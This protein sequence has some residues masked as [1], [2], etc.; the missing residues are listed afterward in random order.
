MH[1]RFGG[2]VCGVAFVIPRKMAACLTAPIAATS[3]IY[4]VKSEHL[5]RI[6]SN[7]TYVRSQAYGM[8]NLANM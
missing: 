2:K 7:L 8:E 4:G 3:N 5:D 1:F 6:L